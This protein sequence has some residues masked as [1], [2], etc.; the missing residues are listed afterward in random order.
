MTLIDISNKTGLSYK[1]VRAKAVRMGI[2]VEGHIPD[3]HIN[4]L[5]FDYQNGFLIIPSKMN[6]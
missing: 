6:K 3:A 2:N 1:E 5:S 4:S